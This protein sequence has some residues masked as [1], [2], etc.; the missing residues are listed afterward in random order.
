MVA[1][2]AL[3]RQ[4]SGRAMALRRAGMCRG[5]VLVSDA[6]GVERVEDALACMLG[7]FAYWPTCDHQLLADGPLVTDSGSALLWLRNVPDRPATASS[8][9]HEPPAVLP[10]RLTVALQDAMQ[11]SGRQVRL[12]ASAAGATMPFAVNAQTIARL[13]STLRSRL[14]MLQQ[15]VRYCAAPAASAAGALL[16]LLPGIAARQVMVVPSEA[17]PDTATIARAISRYHPESLTLTRDQAEAFARACV[18]T[19]VCAGLRDTALL[20]ADTC[21]VPLDLRLHFEPLVARLDVA[22]ILPEAG[23][24]YIV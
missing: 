11:P 1:G 8:E 23:D 15:S 17:N 22:Y 13:G 4:A 6:V 2:A 9:S 24:V 19:D 7:G 16:D 12:L 5:D 20:I 14:G 10:M 3:L 18:D 21:P